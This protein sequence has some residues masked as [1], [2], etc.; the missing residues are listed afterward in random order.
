[1]QKLKLFE[2]LIIFI[3]GIS[4]QGKFSDIYESDLQYLIEHSIFI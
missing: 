4:K 1:M 2:Y 3:I